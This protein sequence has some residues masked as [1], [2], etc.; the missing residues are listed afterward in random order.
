VTPSSSPGIFHLQIAS[1]PSS[2]TTSQPARRYAI[3]RISQR[4][5]S[6]LSSHAP[7]HTH[8]SLPH[9]HQP[10]FTPSHVIIGPSSHRSHVIIGPIFTPSHVIIGPLFQVNEEIVRQVVRITAK[11]K[12]PRFLRLLQTMLGPSDTPLPRVQQ[13]VMLC[14]SQNRTAHVTFRGAAGAELRQALVANDDHIL[15]PRGELAYHIE[16]IALLG[17]CSKG[18][19]LGAQA[20]VRD[21][22]P[23]DD[24]LE[25]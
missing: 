10:F 17:E 1:L 14:I 13:L 18:Q 2:R 16:F 21:I 3:C 8:T 15:N 23:F 22:L 24:L 6:Q 19:C 7:S 9:D 11:E 5:R 25:R 20:L 12:G 4:Q